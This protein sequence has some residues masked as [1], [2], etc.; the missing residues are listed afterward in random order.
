[1]TTAS[2]HCMCI[3]SCCCVAPHQG[4]FGMGCL[5]RITTEFG[6]DPSA[7]QRFFEF[8]E[9]SAQPLTSP[10]CLSPSLTSPCRTPPP[11]P[12]SPP[13]V[14]PLLPP[15]RGGMAPLL[16]P[17]LKRSDRRRLMGSAGKSCCWTRSS[18]QRHSLNK[19]RPSPHRH[20]P[21]PPFLHHQQPS[22]HESAAF[23]HCGIGFQCSKAAV[24]RHPQFDNPLNQMSFCLMQRSPCTLPANDVLDR[25]RRELTAKL[26]RMSS[27]ERRAFLTKQQEV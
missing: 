5:G 19:R 6:T 14:P 22:P 18:S 8:V 3:W 25:Q 7:L 21:L 27:E 10:S 9:R 1:M 4:D 16:P 26:Q 20:A 17:N 12:P 23:E 2:L 24:V 13:F 15:G 11:P